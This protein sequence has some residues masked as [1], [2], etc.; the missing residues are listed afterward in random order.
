MYERGEET[1][2]FTSEQR[3]LLDSIQLLLSR[4]E[5]GDKEELYD[6]V[7]HVS[8]VLI[9]HSDYTRERSSLIY[10]SRIRGYNTEYKQWRQS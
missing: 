2:Q 3:E 1:V 5:N 8:V 9:C 4:W 6:L 10:Y 7:S